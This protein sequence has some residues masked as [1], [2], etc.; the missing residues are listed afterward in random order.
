MLRSATAAQPIIAVSM[1]LVRTLSLHV[2]LFIVSALQ[3]GTPEL[4]EFLLVRIRIACVKAD[5]IQ[6]S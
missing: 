5:P 6:T 4:H 2:S 3:R 1:K